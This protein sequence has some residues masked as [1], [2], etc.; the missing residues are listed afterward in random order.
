MAFQR[1]SGK[2]YKAT[3]GLCCKCECFFKHGEYKL[4]KGKVLCDKCLVV[5]EKEEDEKRNRR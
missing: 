5:F 2:K 3:F 1:E 4:K